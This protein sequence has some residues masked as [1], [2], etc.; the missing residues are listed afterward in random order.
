MNFVLD[1][2]LLLF[3]D[4][5]QSKVKGF[6]YP[7][8]IELIKNQENTFYV[9]GFSILEIYNIKKH[10]SLNETLN[11]LHSKFSNLQFLEYNTDKLSVD[12][13]KYG[14][15]NKYSAILYYHLTGF[16]SFLVHQIILSK[17]IDVSFDI[18]HCVVEKHIHNFF[19][20]N[21]KATFKTVSHFMKNDSINYII[22]CTNETLREL[23]CACTKDDVWKIIGGTT[24]HND[25]LFRGVD[26]PE[27]FRYA[28]YIVALFKTKYS[29]KAS[30][31]QLSFSFID[32]LIAHA[33]NKEFA[34]LSADKDLCRYLIKYGTKD[35]KIIVRKMWDIDLETDSNLFN[36]L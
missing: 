7:S 8:F 15:L 17:N 14:Y 1:T 24:I 35:N 30:K 6:K 31:I 32:L 12:F 27:Y 9:T 4:E 36:N 22:Y 28:K 25:F 20:N 21:E 13:S 3:G 23:N 18:I 2:C 11:Y 26:T 29:N 16:L 10:N 5:G 19:N 33:S 34:V